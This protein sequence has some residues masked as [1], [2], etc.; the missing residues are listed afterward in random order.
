[1][2]NDPALLTNPDFEDKGNT[3][4]HLAARLGVY[5]IVVRFQPHFPLS[6][7]E[8]WTSLEELGDPLKY[9]WLTRESGFSHRSW[10]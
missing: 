1:V 6:R 8:V 2:K 5:E 9:F 10:T 7:T 4:L 3:S